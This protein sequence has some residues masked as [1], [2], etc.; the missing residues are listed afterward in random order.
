MVD[1]KVSFNLSFP[2]ADVE[3]VVLGFGT[4]KPEIQC[5]ANQVSSQVGGDI[6]GEPIDPVQNEFG[7]RLPN[8]TAARTLT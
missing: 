6:T 5:I 1:A 8:Q 2:S 4:E 3:F 7:Q